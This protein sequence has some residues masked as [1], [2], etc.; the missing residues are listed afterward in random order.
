MN[1]FNF[2]TTLTFIKFLGDFLKTVFYVY[3]NNYNNSLV[4]SK[5]NIS[6]WSAILHEVLL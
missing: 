4:F 5:L 2:R 6:S 3:E 1:A